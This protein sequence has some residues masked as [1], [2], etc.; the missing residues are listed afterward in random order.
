VTTLFA[1]RA[2]ELDRLT[3]VYQKVTAGTAGVCLLSGIAGS[4]KSTL[5]QAFTSKM[6]A[7]DANAVV[8]VGTCDPHTGSGDPY[9]PFL[10]VLTQLTGN[11]ESKLAQGA[12]SEANANRLK[13]AGSISLDLLLEYAPDL[14]GTFIPGSSIIIKV[15][16]QVAEKAGM[17]DG[18]R[19][20]L[21]ATTAV[22]T[23]IDQQRIVNSYTTLIRKLSAHFPLIMVID[24]LQWTDTATATLIFH[25]AQHLNDARVMLIG[26]YRGSDVALGRGENRH[27]MTQ[28]INELKR[29]HGDILIDLDAETEEQRRG[30]VSAIVDSQPNELDRS[31]RDA[32]FRHT[33]GHALFTIELLRALQDRGCLVQSER[34]TWVVTP[35]LD[36]SVLPSRV[37]GVVEER[38]G[39]LED[40]LRELLRT[41]SVEGESFTVEILA[42]IAE[43][44]ERAL[45]KTLSS[46]LE[47][48][49]QLVT[50]GEVQKIGRKWLSHYNFSHALFQQYLYNDLGRRERMMLHGDVAGL[51][52]ELYEGQLDQMTVQLAWHWRTAGDDEKAYHYTMLAAQ[53]ALRIGAFPEAL[54][55]LDAALELIPSLP[56]KERA[57][58]ELDVQVGRAAAV[59]ATKGWD[60]PAA[61]DIYERCH[62]LS[63]LTGPTA[64]MAPILYGLWAMNMLHRRGDA[65]WQI[66]S[67]CLAIGEQIGSDEVIM[68]AR[69]AQANTRFWMGDFP[70]TL[71]LAGEAMKSAKE[72]NYAERLGQDPRALILMFSM[73]GS[74]ITGSPEAACE[75]RREL[76][77]LVER[78]GHTFTTAIALQATAWQSCHERDA[79]TAFADASRLADLASY[80]SFPFYAA[81]GK[82]LRAWARVL[83]GENAMDE[84]EEGHASISE[85]GGRMLES[86]YG[87]VAGECCLVTGEHQRGIELLAGIIG[88]AD[89]SGFR[90]YA[91]ELHRVRG[92]L[93]L[94]AGDSEAA[95][96]SFRSAIDV[97]SQQ[98]AVPFELRATEALAAIA[99]EYAEQE[100]RSA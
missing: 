77:A 89:A 41:A 90:A 66:A 5:I 7:L 40:Q 86:L 1:G 19:K 29:Y 74:W 8:A 93:Q 52:E 20:R 68:Q 46:E 18:V 62:A 75:R 92:Q 6:Q 23:A 82:V 97:A 37:E 70:A 49:H 94:A 11:V 53:R 60:S 61:I 32:L 76:M 42:R 48:R 96:A 79:A 100:E 58:S 2:A 31:F 25:L 39:R 84:L 54:Q 45:L 63:A 33:R 12:I 36:W 26:S 13:K 81:M 30:F 83:R 17:L 51:I 47:K 72:D 34:K 16:S 59:K 69:I 65:A 88:P 57:A 67:D 38:I 91:A 64:R 10:D 27:P 71:E 95:A 87:I 99:P 78:L 35:D 43:I 22:D 4:G 9:L 85:F 56:E 80:H 24:D 98:N 44:S 28:V 21:E 50:E 55:H 15:A 73:F 3:S 14:I